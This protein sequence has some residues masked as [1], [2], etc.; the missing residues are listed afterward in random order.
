MEVDGDKIIV[1]KEWIESLLD[2]RDG[3]NLVRWWVMENDFTD[4]ELGIVV[5]EYFIKNKVV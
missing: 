2:K 1:S 5:R 4:A 3:F